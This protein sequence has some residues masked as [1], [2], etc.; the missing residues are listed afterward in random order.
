MEVRKMKRIFVT[1]TIALLLMVALI[2]LKP[3]LA[4]S[5]KPTNL[6]FSLFLPPTHQIVKNVHEPW[7]VLRTLKTKEFGMVFPCNCPFSR[8]QALR[9]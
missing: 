7:I 4:A 1:V 3:V 8:L 2:E 5:D 6:K 9:R